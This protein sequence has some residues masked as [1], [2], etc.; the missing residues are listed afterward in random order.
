MEILNLEQL[1]LKLQEAGRNNILTSN[2]VKVKIEKNT[3]L[4]FEKVLDKLYDFNSHVI[5]AKYV[6]GDYR[7]ICELSSK[8]HLVIILFI[9]DNVRIATAIK[10][11][12]NVEKLLKKSK[13]IYT[14]VKKTQTGTSF[15]V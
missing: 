4:T 12:K 2:K 6:G 15:N 1:H 7:I 14:I 5:A 9:N 13:I 8:F 3:G 11:S 10:S